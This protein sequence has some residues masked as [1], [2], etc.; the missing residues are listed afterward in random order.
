MKY[1]ILRSEKLKNEMSLLY[2]EYFL[3][4]Y[5]LNTFIGQEKQW[6]K[7]NLDFIY[8]NRG[9]DTLLTINPYYK[10]YKFKEE[11]GEM[12]EYVFL[13]KYFALKKLYITNYE[14]KDADLFFKLL[15][16]YKSTFSLYELIDIV[17]NNKKKNYEYLRIRILCIVRKFLS[18]QFLVIKSKS[19]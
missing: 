15:I 6:I 19:V 5:S 2:K 8:H 10:I 11:P 14:L 17:T 16:R 1:K 4:H 18:Y 12:S 13:P 7:N 9:E 3:E